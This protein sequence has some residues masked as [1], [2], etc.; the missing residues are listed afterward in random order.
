ML[1][2]KNLC[3]F[4]PG[5]V[6]KCTPRVVS[7]ICENIV[8]NIGNIAKYFTESCSTGPNSNNQFFLNLLIQSWAGFNAS[9]KCTMLVP[10]DLD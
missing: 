2:L 1:P 7:H 5:S 8:I 10:I 3:F 6:L 9:T 4:W